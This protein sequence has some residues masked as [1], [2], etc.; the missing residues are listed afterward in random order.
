E[1]GR[2]SK[3][4]APFGDRDGLLYYN[5][6]EYNSANQLMKIVNYHSNAITFFDFL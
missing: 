1:K 2:I 3:V 6:Y 5:L 4:S